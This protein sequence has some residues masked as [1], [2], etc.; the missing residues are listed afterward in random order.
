[1]SEKVENAKAI[2]EFSEAEQEI[3]TK[4]AAFPF[5]LVI[6]KCVYKNL[7]LC[8]DAAN[9]ISLHIGQE[10][11]NLTV[12]LSEIG[13]YFNKDSAVCDCVWPVSSTPSARCYIELTCTPTRKF[14]LIKATTVG[15]VVLLTLNSDDSLAH[16]IYIIR[17]VYLHALPTDWSSHSLLESYIKFVGHHFMNNESVMTHFLGDSGH[18]DMLLKMIEKE[19]EKYASRSYGKLLSVLNST[20]RLSILPFLDLCFKNRLLSFN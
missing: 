9:S 16:F 4:I 2:L 18:D 7:D 3:T 20:L 14:Q 6:G 10:L 1:M 11:T 8:F 5:Y 17:Q 12:V 15:K 13:P 19:G